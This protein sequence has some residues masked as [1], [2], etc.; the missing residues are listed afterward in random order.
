MVGIWA[1]FNTQNNL[2]T[3]DFVVDR[4]RSRNICIKSRP[5]AKRRFSV[6]YDHKLAT[7]CT[8]LRETTDENL[9][10]DF[11][12]DSPQARASSAQLASAKTAL[13]FEAI[14]SAVALCIGRGVERI[15]VKR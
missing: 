2:G 3:S 1:G 9:H 11:W 10:D 5:F 8:H 12:G 15:S 6:E 7:N 14:L 4:I 13:V